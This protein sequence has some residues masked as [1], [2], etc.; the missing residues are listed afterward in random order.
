MIV[1][2]PYL[3]INCNLLN[4]EISPLEKQWL[5]LEEYCA[6]EKISLDIDRSMTFPIMVAI[7]YKNAELCRSLLAL[8]ADFET[9]DSNGLTPLSHA[10]LTGFQDAIPLLLEAGANPNKASL[11]L[12]P[13]FIAALI[14]N[15]AACELLLE[16]KADVDAIDIG[17][18]S[19]HLKKLFARAA[20]I[21][22]IPLEEIITPKVA[23]QGTGATALYLACSTN[24]FDLAE[25]LIKHQAKIEVVSNLAGEAFDT[26]FANKNVR[27]CRLL[28][29]R[30]ELELSKNPLDIEN[31]LLFSAINSVNSSETKFLID[32]GANINL[33]D[34]KGKTLL[35]T[36]TTM[37]NGLEK[38]KLL[39]N[40][41][42]DV[43]I[44]DD[45]G[46]TAL[47][48][49]ILLKKISEIKLLIAANADVNVKNLKDSTPLHEATYGGNLEIVKLLFAAGADVNAKDSKKETAL[50]M[51]T[52]RNFSEITELLISS[53]A[54]V[55]VV[56]QEGVTPLLNFWLFNT[57]LYEPAKIL[58][59]DDGLTPKLVELR[60][61]GHRFSL[62]NEIFSSF[63]T[64]I[65]F[66]A[67]I[68]TI[69]RF[70][71]TY[72]ESRP[73]I[74]DQTV[75]ALANAVDQTVTPQKYTERLQKGELVA[76][77]VGCINHACSA[78]LYK[79]K[80]ALGNQGLQLNQTLE[81]GIRFYKIHAMESVQE[82]ITLLVQAKRDH[83]I[84]LDP[85]N[86]KTVKEQVAGLQDKQMLFFEKGIHELLKLDQVHFI[87]LPKQ[88]TGNCGWKGAKMTL[89]SIDFFLYGNIHMSKEILDFDRYLSVQSIEYLEKEPLFQELLSWDDL[90]H[91][92]V[93][94]CAKRT[95][96]YACRKIL[97][98]K[99][100][101]IN[102]YST[103]SNG[104]LLRRAV[105]QDADDLVIF[106]L[107]QGADPH[108]KDAI[109]W[110]PI[111]YA[112]GLG[113]REI[114]KCLLD[115]GVHVDSRTS[116]DL[117]T[118]LISAA[119]RNQGE[120]IDFLLQKGAD[121]NLVD[122]KGQS[123]LHYA[124]ER[125]YLKIC[126]ALAGH[127][128]DFSTK[129]KDGS[130]PLSLATLNNHEN[131]I[132]YFAQ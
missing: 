34:E 96:E 22:G 90:N 114:A 84:V 30:K 45:N 118:P 72:P 65:T 9:H 87:K 82:A 119:G 18:L 13:L 127:G 11:N 107:E 48:I 130:T 1:S 91:D 51:S 80:I 38:V 10:I 131:I 68:S 6:S 95:K 115:H 58:I 66:P 110:A 120:M 40:F 17:P 59:K 129:A 57:Q 54:D 52:G 39:I 104:S 78:V 7:G 116:A 53:G 75:P 49:A 14:P 69:E 29:G 26:A 124:A 71:E 55:R 23:S 2:N 4:L 31:I 36:F 67:L 112:A 85:L 63:H 46:E 106:L 126:Q 73:L 108:V 117:I 35:H 122:Y 125:G 32:I 100:H 132:E 86:Q 15:L 64:S 60:M 70:I 77:Q 21:Q 99:P 19:P 102:A 93:F 97:E 103:V 81:P 76:L 33:K 121:V 8:G 89:K 43:N 105:L 44:K 27:I 56:S 20:E 111:H 47:Y 92:L 74:T 37:K 101:L 62:K 113:K 79:D 42:V 98:R 5:L 83:F 28:R 3:K 25:L 12:P 61:L 88:K 109:G 16:Y 41:G 128:V 24:N 123:A 50:L 94:A